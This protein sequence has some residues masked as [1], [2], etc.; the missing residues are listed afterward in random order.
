[1]LKG[2]SNSTRDEIEKKMEFMEKLTKNK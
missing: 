2:S 1:M